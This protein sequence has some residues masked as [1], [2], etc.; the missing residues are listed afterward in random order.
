MLIMQNTYRFIVLIVGIQFS[1]LLLSGCG[2]KLRGSGYE[3]VSGQTVFL[4]SYQPYGSLTKNIREK[5]DRFVNIADVSEASQ[6]DNDGIQITDLTTQKKTISVDANGRPAE[7]QTII[8]V[9]VTYHLKGKRQ[10]EQFSLQRDYRFNSTNSLAHD[11]ELELIT[12]EML[13][14]LSGRIVGQFIRQLSEQKIDE[15]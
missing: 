9:A 10:Q 2:F 6:T 12:D 4:Q 13:Y 5:L 3:T 7:Y 1:I 14:E 11:R 15:T 8:S